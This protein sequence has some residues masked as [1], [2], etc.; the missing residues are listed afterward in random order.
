MKGH[1]LIA[2][3]NPDGTAKEGTKYLADVWNDNIGNLH[4]FVRKSG[5]N[6]IPD[7]VTQ[8]HKALK[9]NWVST[10][11]YNTSAIETQTVDD[12][13]LGSDGN[14]Y[15][16]KNDGVVNDNPVGSITG[17]W[18]M[19]PINAVIQAQLDT[20]QNLLI[21]G[22]NIKSVNGVSLLGAGDLTV[23]A[24]GGGYAG[25]V[26][27]T[28]VNSTTNPSYKQLSYTPSPTETDISVTVNNNTVL[29]E[30]YIFDGDVKTTII[31]AGEWGFTFDRFVDNSAG[32]TRLKFDIFA[33]TSGGVE[34]VLFSLFST[35]INDLAYV[36]ENILKIQPSYTVNATDRIG[37][38][39]YGTT[40]R[41]SNTT[42]SF[43]LGNGDASH[44][45][46]PLEI[47]HSQLRARDEVD[48]HPISAITGL[49]TALDSKQAT[50]TGAASTITSSDLAT[51]RVVITSSSTGKITVSEI[52]SLELAYL[53]GLS[54]NL[55]T[56]LDSKQATIADNGLALT[57]LNVTGA[58]DI[59]ADLVDTDLIIVNNKKSTLSR[60][61]K[62][63]RDL[64]SRNFGFVS[65]KDFGAVGDGVTNDYQAFR[66]AIDSNK[67][68]FVPIGDYYLASTLVA[69][70]PL[71]L[72]GSG[73]GR[74]R[75]LKHSTN[76]NNT[77]LDI[78]SSNTLFEDFEINI[79]SGSNVLTNGYGIRLFSDTV[80][81]QSNRANRI[82]IQNQNNSIGVIESSTTIKPTKTYFDNI[83]LLDSNNIALEI[84][85][86]S[87]TYF[88][89]VLIDTSRGYDGV[90]VERGFGIFIKRTEGL[91][92]DKVE[93]LDS[94]AGIWFQPQNA[95][96]YIKYVFISNS[97]F[98]TNSDY[99]AVIIT[100]AGGDIHSVNFNNCWF[101][102][103][104]AQPTEDYSEARGVVIHGYSVPDQL[105][106]INFNQC[107]IFNNGRHGVELQSCRNISFNNC[108][109]A[110][111]GSKQVN[112]YDG[113]Y[114]GNDVDNFRILGNY[115]GATA[116]FTGTQK[117][118]INLTSTTCTG[119]IVK[120]NF[121]GGNLTGGLFNAGVTN[122]IV[123]DN[124]G[125]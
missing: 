57:K 69:D 47:R 44:F 125:A 20:K 54:S 24:G 95:A 39:V 93:A 76:A 31:P 114:V 5:Y 78:K 29:L 22:T 62:F 17:N 50:I 123:S 12:I 55:Q 11:V 113:I 36:K 83:E 26:Y 1:S 79:Q 75:L 52:T 2:N 46:T 110:G 9:A 40:T 96:H 91:W 77:C 88:S 105:T 102:S 15:K 80:A 8:L 86:G 38:K 63:V 21:S 97:A 121:L 68:V 23:S 59:N 124:I 27:F 108:D 61:W 7:D 84:D 6:L 98:D 34:T 49:Q 112:T 117:Y 35:E 60:F 109:I 85:G 90:E 92:L 51:D 48:S 42:I 100:N 106:Q 111:N 16:C 4:E 58:T 101:A 103:N 116:D 56:Q 32:D 18:E 99:G 64:F 67:N 19:L 33:R 66:D 37:V 107:R 72:R 45:S 10:Y 118:G 81:Y 120:D 65:V 30:D 3:G 89:N 71:I 70:R 94:V 104:G 13:V 74:T 122:S 115:S 119:A 41:T 82:K 25:N 87:D 73:I 14:Y 43:K 28:T 53:S